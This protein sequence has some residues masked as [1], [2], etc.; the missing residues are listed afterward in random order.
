MGQPKNYSP[1]TI[2]DLARSGITP[3]VAKRCG[4]QELS[5]EQIREMGFNHRGWP[6]NNGGYLLPY[7]RL[8]GKRDQ[9]HDRVRLHVPIT[10]HDNKTGKDKE[11][12]YLQR[13]DS[14]CGLYLPRLLSWSKLAKDVTA[15]L[16]I[17]EGEKKAAKS[18]MMG[19]PT[20]GLGGIWNG[21]P[22]G[23]LL[24]A[25]DQFLFDGRRVEI[26]FDPHDPSKEHDP[27]VEE[28]AH[29]L[30]SY[31]YERGAVLQMVK[32]PD[33]L[34]LDDF[35]AAGHTIEQ[36]RKL[37]RV[38]I[39]ERD[40]VQ[41]IRLRKQKAD[42][43]KES[44]AN[45][46][47]DSMSRR[48]EF[49]RTSNGELLFFDKKE[50]TIFPLDDPDSR[51]LRA[52][53]EANYGLNGAATEWKA[54]HEALANHAVR[55]GTSTEVYALA[56]YARAT[57][58]LYIANG[59]Q[60]MFKVTEGGWCVVDNG[61]DHVLMATHGRM[62]AVTPA[63]KANPAAFW[64]VIGTPNLI[65]GA[66]LKADDAKLLYGINTVAM[67]FPELMPTRAM[68]CFHGPRGSGKSSAGRAVGR[69]VFGHGFEVSEID[70]DK[71][72]GLDAAMIS[73]AFVV[74]DNVDGRIK[75]MENKLAIASTGGKLERR[76]LYTTLE[77]YEPRIISFLTFT[78]RDPRSFTRADVVDRLLYL[79]CER[80]ADFVEEA[81]LLARIDANRAAFWR[82]LLDTLPAVLKALKRRKPLR[83]KTRMADFASFALAVGPVLDRKV[84]SKRIAAAI[85][86]SEREKLEFI[87][88]M[89]ILPEAFEALMNDVSLKALATKVKTNGQGS[90]IEA[91]ELTDMTTM[92]LLGW[93][94]KCWPLG[95]N[96]FPYKRADTLGL[97]LRD[98]LASLKERG[99]PIE[100]K[101]DGHNKH[102]NYSL[103]WPED[104]WPKLDD[105]PVKF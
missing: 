68:N 100:A 17:A 48:G 14:G 94:Q 45:A 26:A 25:L 64:D 95:K 40:I 52:Y 58:T 79:K 54:I 69:S 39:G 31:L 4:I 93:L 29:R 66:A 56:H 22:K 101:Y 63:P 65:N 24:P 70:P 81:A 35:F 83:L 10:I 76:K 19:I 98:Q 80:R 75:K 61:T 42:L 13:K 105:G 38:D 67:L 47:R 28:A 32:L 50:K 3:E 5:A 86:D 51:E 9:L 60:Q 99:I 36:Y 85:N 20:V 12:R 37:P 16:T 33:G 57:N 103:R 44:V 104:Q 43:R 18:C 71:L 89:S 74:F 72:D 62:T 15:L 11:T 102:W 21:V 8:D 23:Q 77:N 49:I 27:Q 46:V 6:I 84:D 7:C 87:S 55:S 59:E 53:I 88:E 30:A 91:V 82:W 41:Q 1:E 73:H 2:R 96:E 78:S 97:D 92:Q 34:K 90:V